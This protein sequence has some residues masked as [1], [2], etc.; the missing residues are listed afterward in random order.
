MPNTVLRTINTVVLFLFTMT[1]VC[2]CVCVFI[3]SIVSWKTGQ[4]ASL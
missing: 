1:G 3:F 4:L 2:V